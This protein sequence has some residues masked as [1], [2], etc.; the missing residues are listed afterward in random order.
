MG[1]ES[2]FAPSRSSCRSAS[3]GNI[4][5]VEAGLCPRTTG[6]VS[7]LLGEVDHAYEL[8]KTGLNPGRRGDVNADRSQQLQCGSRPARPKDLEVGGDEAG[9]RLTGLGV[10]RHRGD[11]GEGVGVGIETG[12]DEV[13]DV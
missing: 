10:E 8:G 4:L 13:G 7:R 12:I 2:P 9:Y 6:L 1:F 3:G 11:M 5:T